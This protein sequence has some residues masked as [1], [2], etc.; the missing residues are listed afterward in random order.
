MTALTSFGFIQAILA[1]V[2]LAF[3]VGLIVWL[4]NA[5]TMRISAVAW[6]VA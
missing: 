6:R 4:W 2:G 3:A 5:V 1:L